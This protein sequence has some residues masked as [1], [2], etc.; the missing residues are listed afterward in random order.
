[1]DPI[2]AIAG[3]VALGTGIYTAVDSATERKN[4]RKEAA[5]N[6]VFETWKENA[7]Y[8]QQLADERENWKMQND[9]NSPANQM[10]LYGNAGL[11][12]NL[13]YGGATHSQA[14]AIGSPPSY[15]KADMNSAEFGWGN[16]GFN[17]IAGG[18]GEMYNLAHKRATIDNVEES[19]SLMKQEAIFKQANTAKTLQDTAK[20]EFDLKQAN[21]LFDST[22][23]QAQLNN[24]KT[25]QDTIYTVSEN[26]RK[27]LSNS[28]DVKLTLEK[29]ITEKIAHTKDAEQIKLLQQQLISLK[30]DNNIRTYE[31]K[32]TEMGIYKND[33]WY[34]RALMNLSHGNMATPPIVKEA[35]PFTNSNSGDPQPKGGDNDPANYKSPW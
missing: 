10:K 33:P 13:I 23:Q 1:M 28:T 18:L 21:A 15:T 16:E 26:Q 14:S 7:R 35:L 12:S 20:G 30:Q 9:Y 2:T 31:D 32:L 19:T 24:E 17:Q 8:K 25:R 3:L 27:E 5:F 34:F 11:N 29:I 6:N 4:K 22:V